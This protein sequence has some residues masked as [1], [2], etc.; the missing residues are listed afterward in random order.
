MEEKDKP[1]LA[2]VEAQASRLTFQTHQDALNFADH[3]V[4]DSKRCIAAYDLV[5]RYMDGDYYIN[6]NLGLLFAGSYKIYDFIFS[7][8]PLPMFFLVRVEKDCQE[9]L[10]IEDNC[11]K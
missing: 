10:Q 9:R 5:K 3:V 11:L 1:E 7:A 2:L 8:I 6:I 4:E